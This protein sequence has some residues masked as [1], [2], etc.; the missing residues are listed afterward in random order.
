MTP[1]LDLL[2]HTEAAPALDTAWLGKMLHEIPEPD[3]AQRRRS[4]LICRLA[5]VLEDM[6]DRGVDPKLGEE[7]MG[8]RLREDFETLLEAWEGGRHPGQPPRG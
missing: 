5:A 6:G 7:A 1:P 8:W 4:G 2:R 3:E